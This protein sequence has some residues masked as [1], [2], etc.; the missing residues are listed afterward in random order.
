MSTN[1]A[2]CLDALKENKT[3]FCNQLL[4]FLTGTQWETQYITSLN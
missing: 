3:T 2:S 4:S 1:P